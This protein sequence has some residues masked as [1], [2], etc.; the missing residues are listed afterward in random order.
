MWDL[1][2]F[3]LKACTHLT[4]EIDGQETC[5]ADKQTQV[6][7]KG[8]GQGHRAGAR[9]FSLRKNRRLIHIWLMERKNKRSGKHI[10]L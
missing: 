8:N 3:L 2:K 9:C 10:F 7:E 6:S 5:S 1:N 4:L